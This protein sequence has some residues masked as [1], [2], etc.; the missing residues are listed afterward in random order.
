VTKLYYLQDEHTTPK[1]HRDAADFCPGEI[2][3]VETRN[4]IKCGYVFPDQILYTIFN[5]TTEYQHWQ[6]ALCPH[7][8]HVF[9]DIY[10]DKFHYMDFDNKSM[11]KKIS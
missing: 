4:R 7:S 8:R 2:W 1:E 10:S 11:I 6:H 5:A 3:A 9:H